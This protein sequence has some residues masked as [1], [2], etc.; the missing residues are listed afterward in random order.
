MK[1]SD[2]EFEQIRV[3]LHGKF[4][5]SLADHKKALVVGRLRKI[6]TQEGYSSFSEYIDSLH[7]DSSNHDL[8]ILIDRLSTNHTFFFRESQHF[9][10]FSSHILP[11]ITQQLKSKRQSDFRVWCAAASTGEEPYSIMMTMMEYFKDNY[12]GWTAG[13]LATDISS[14]VLEHAVAGI[15]EED[16]MRGIP[17]NMIKKY[18]QPVGERKWR[19]K[20][21]VRRE[22]LF[23]K[24]NLMNPL[25]FKKQFHVIFCRNVM[26]YFDQ[27]T[28]KELIKR[29]YQV[30]APGGYLFVGHSESIRSAECPYEYVCPA[31]FRK[32]SK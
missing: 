4:G 27:H 20:E 23:R 16:R 11:E 26:I 9:S 19:F 18:L 6:L 17:D 12:A 8:Q 25:P 14:R 2:H 13:L 32:S 21:F 29:L 7:R 22:I 5:I 15:Y 24:F 1:L 30:T 31:I 10:Y 3:L 28:R